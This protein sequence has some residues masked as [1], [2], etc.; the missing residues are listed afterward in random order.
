MLHA[1]KARPSRECGLL[2]LP[3]GYGIHRFDSGGGHVQ[4]PL[5]RNPGKKILPILRVPLL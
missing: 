4:L 5:S 1:F 3:K 2:P